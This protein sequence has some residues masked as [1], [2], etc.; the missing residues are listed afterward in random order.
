MKYN[1]IKN[2]AKLIVPNIVISVITRIFA[3][4]LQNVKT[5]GG[6]I[7][8]P[9]NKFEGK[10]II[11]ANSRVYQ[12]KV[13]KY[14]YISAN[15]VIS[16]T[17]IGRYSSIGNWV[18]TGIG[19]HPTD[20]VSTHPLFH[21]SFVSASLGFIP[22]DVGEKYETH[23]ILESGYHVEI[24]SDVWIGDRVMI[25]DGIIIGDGAIVGAGSIV[26]KNVMPYEIVGGVTARHIRYRFSADKIKFLLALKWWNM[27]ETRIRNNV[28]LFSDIDKF[29]L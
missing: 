19:R 10:N 27:E 4:F 16:K 15:T 26:N 18:C 2:L 17:L 24:G 29:N 21:S 9:R 12:S 11:L 25:M 28:N 6:V 3:F 8:D 7:F 5:H 23:K 14:T 22:F 20:F 13:G 1:F